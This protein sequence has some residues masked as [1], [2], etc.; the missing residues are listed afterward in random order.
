[1][2]RL[3]KSIELLQV[4]T[5]AEKTKW[6]FILTGDESWFFYYTPNSRIWLPPDAE[7]PEVAQ[8]LINM[9]N[10]MVMV[11]WNPSGLYVNRFLERGTSFNSSYFIDYVLSD[12]ECLPVLQ[13]AV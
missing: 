8:R 7:T 13:T 9:P 11:F 3:A 2:D 10:I 4:L 5:R 1:V 6:Q 12:I